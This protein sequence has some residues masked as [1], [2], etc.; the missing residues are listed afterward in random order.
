MCARIDCMSMQNL[1]SVALIVS[2]HDRKTDGRTDMAKAD[3]T[4]I[5]DVTHE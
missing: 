4:N 2:G 1:E 5:A 3:R